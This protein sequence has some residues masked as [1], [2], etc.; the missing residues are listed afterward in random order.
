MYLQQIRVMA[1]FEGMK[2]FNMFDLV[3]AAFGKTSFADVACMKFAVYRETPGE[4]Q[5]KL[6]EIEL[7]P[8]SMDELSLLDPSTLGGAYH[9]YLMDQK[10]EHFRV[11]ESLRKKLK[12]NPMAIRFTETHDLH[13][14]IT[15]FDTTVAGELGLVAFNAIH[16]FGIISKQRWKWM[17]RIYLTMMFLFVPFQYRAFK[18]NLSLGEKM[19]Q[20]CSSTMFVRFDTMLAMPLSEVRQ[21]LG[22][23]D[24]DRLAIMHGKRSAFLTFIYKMMGREL[25]MPQT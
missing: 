13:H 12:D 18:H 4:L 11:S 14:L 23:K 10:L 3:R 17:K 20:D 21:Q 1:T 6:D 9:Q 24:D 15:G 8:I 19:A 5:S 2:K 7:Q 25:P 16:D 22:I